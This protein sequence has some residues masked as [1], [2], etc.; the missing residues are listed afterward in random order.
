MSIEHRMPH[1]KR[2]FLRG[3]STLEVRVA[4]Y[5]DGV[6]EIL[7]ALVT[8][9]GLMSEMPCIRCTPCLKVINL[10]YHNRQEKTW[11]S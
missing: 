6:A 2:L 4:H 9:R 10:S 11:T 7:L 3:K 8:S 1:I 5:T